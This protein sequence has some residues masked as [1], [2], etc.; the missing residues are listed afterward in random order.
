MENAF[1]AFLLIG[2]S[3][4]AV[5]VI[6]TFVLNIIRRKKYGRIASNVFFEKYGQRLLN[7][8]SKNKFF[9]KFNE[10]IAYKISV[11]NTV[12]YEKNRIISVFVILLAVVIVFVM[13]LI[14]LFLFMPYWYIALSYTAFFATALLFLLQLLAEAIMNKYLKKLPEAIK[15]LQSR[16]LTK[17]SISKAIQV[18]IPD[19]P[20]GIKAEM[21]RIYDAMKQ[22]ET[23]KTKDVFWEIDKKY[24]N[25]HMSVLLDLIRLAHYNGGTDAVKEQF[26]SMIKD[27]LEDL[28]NQQDLRGAAMSYIIMAVLFTA[29]LP[30]VKMYNASI[31]DP[32]EMAY[33]S[34]RSGMLFAL[35]YVGF[36]LILI[37][38]LFYLKK[39]G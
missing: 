38:V 26:D 2:G 6:I 25:E 22:N 9:V 1:F 15:I 19:L 32:T 20:T 5:C 39:K 30:L 28:E 13:L 31:L 4:C 17:G 21:I 35:A 10:E 29:A 8:F 7:I 36:L 12:S 27:V 34:S 11:F 33:Y 18:S 14:M 23:E 16:F 37:G 24:S 3:V